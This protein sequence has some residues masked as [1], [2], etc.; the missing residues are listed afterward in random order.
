MI[1]Q[2][3]RTGRY[4]GIIGGSCVCKRDD[5]LGGGM[6]GMEREEEYLLISKAHDEWERE[7]EERRREE[8]GGEERIVLVH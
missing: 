5:R 7:R 8:N 6:F 3:K 4:E 2:W 1:K